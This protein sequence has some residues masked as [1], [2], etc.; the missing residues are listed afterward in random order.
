MNILPLILGFILVFAA[1]SLTFLKEAQSVSIAERSIDA[2]F[3]VEIEL[4]NRI[5]LRNYLR[6]A[7]VNRSSS[8]GGGKRRSYCCLRTLSPPMEAS[9][10]NISVLLDPTL[11][12]LHQHPIY[13][14]AAELIKTLYEDSTALGAKR[15]RGWE[16]KLLDGMIAKGRRGI[17]PQRLSDLF[18]DD[19]DLHHLY[20]KILKGTN[21]YTL[22]TLKRGTAPLDHFLSVEKIE[23]ENTFCFSFASRPLLEAAFGKKVADQILENE[24]KQW[25]ASGKQHFATKEELQN[26]LAQG[27]IPD[28]F[29][30]LEP[31]LSFPKK[32]PKKSQI[33]GR[34][35]T[36]GLVLTREIF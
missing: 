10:L 24:K 31:Y 21:C 36:T 29:S 2:A 30:Q 7:H 1:V 22:G 3:R 26:L 8:K 19:P 17:H 20:Y 25:D 18:P 16:K 14:I 27:S 32:I 13:P 28:L 12:D 15:E 35:V 6:A 33:A 34:D 5:A 23:K 9:K 11:V 4:H